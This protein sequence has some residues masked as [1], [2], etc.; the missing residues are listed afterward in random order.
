MPYFRKKPVV[1]RA[2]QL[3]NDPAVAVELA[4][5]CGGHWT[6]DCNSDGSD[7]MQFILIST[8]EGKILASPGDWIIEGVNGEFYP[9]KDDIFR[10]TYD[11]VE[12][13]S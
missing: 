13:R 9:C 8:L 4:R 6:P 10:K 2:H 11:P 12:D 3:T 7:E 1:I 5:W